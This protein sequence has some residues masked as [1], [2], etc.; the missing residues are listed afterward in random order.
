MR[1][2]DG[3]HK[4]AQWMLTKME[5]TVCQGGGVQGV[6]DC[7]GGGE[8]RAWGAT[9]VLTNPAVTPDLP[10]HRGAPQV[11]QSGWQTFPTKHVATIF[12]T[13]FHCQMLEKAMMWQAIVTQP[14]ESQV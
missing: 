1:K 10:S 14:D 4:P 11:D 9:F 13:I 8:A 3:Q 2:A 5:V 12:D 6:G 7:K